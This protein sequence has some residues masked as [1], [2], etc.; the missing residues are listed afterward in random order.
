MANAYALVINSENV[1]IGVQVYPNGLPSTLPS[2]QVACTSEQAANPGLLQL[3][4]GSLVDYVP[5]YQAIQIAQLKTSCGSVISSGFS[6]TSS[7]PGS[8]GTV[9]L[10]TTST[11]DQING[12]GAA[13]VA[14][15]VMQ[16][17]TSWAASG[18]YEPD[19]VVLADG[20]YYVTFGGGTSGSTAPAFPASF[21]TPVTDGSVTWELFGMLVNTAAGRVWL[22]AQDTVACYTAGAKFVN[23]QLGTLTVLENEVNAAS[24]VA[25]VQAVVW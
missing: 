12:G 14:Q 15:G 16:R 21:S 24:T 17:A 7:S 2:N 9:L 6:F 8:S 10:I 23:T 22:T 18:T 25:A 3:V 19:S 11:N 4:S 1:G 20:N 5:G 13:L